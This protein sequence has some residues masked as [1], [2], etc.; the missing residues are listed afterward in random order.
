MKWQAGVDW[1]TLVSKDEE[2]GQDWWKLYS[3]HE[4]RWMMFAGDWKHQGGYDGRLCE[5]LAWGYSE[6]MGYIFRATGLMAEEITHMIPLWASKQF[7][8]TRIDLRVDVDYGRRVTDVA[9]KI[10]EDNKHQSRPSFRLVSSSGEGGDTVYCGSKSSEIFGRVYD[11][12]AEQGKQSG[13]LWRYEVVFRKDYAEEV[14]AD[15][16]VCVLGANYQQCLASVVKTWFSAK[17]V[18]LEIDVRLGD[19]IVLRPKKTGLDK[20]LEWLATQVAPTLHRLI[21][22]GYYD[23]VVAALGVDAIRGKRK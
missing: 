15:V 17:N 3:K 14:L 5:G 16:M 10:Y 8:C 11:K 20:K 6:K 12:S 18:G 2:T 22:S 4:Q 21:E 13:L 9:Q 19:L 23:E 7:R 1:L